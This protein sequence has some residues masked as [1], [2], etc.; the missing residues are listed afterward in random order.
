VPDAGSRAGL[1]GDF[2]R[3]GGYS[4]T[5]SIVLGTT[6]ITSNAPSS[7]LLQSPLEENLRGLRQRLER[8]T[9]QADR[10]PDA[11]QILAVT[12]SVEPDA[13]AEIARLG[14]HDLGENRAPE[15]ERK[16]QAFAD[17]GSDGPNGVPEVRWHFIGHLQRNKAR[18]VARIASVIHSVDSL[19]LLDT[20]ERIAAEEDLQ[21]SI[22]LQVDATG[23]AQ[24]TGFAPDATQAA[25]RRAQSCGRLTLLGIMGMGP[26]EEREGRTTRD[27]FA[28]LAAL[29]AELTSDPSLAD[30]FAGGRCRLSMGMSGDLEEAVSAGTDVVRVGGALF[31]DPTNTANK[32]PGAA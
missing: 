13:A 23:E 10:R 19:E 9:S 4:L 16:A 28:E 32:R 18:R 24:K 22:Y 1:S 2:R 21:L 12:K 5:P 17:F 7:P 29:A 15:L 26:L 14:M 3:G 20:L 27:V 6:P 30:A 31:R 11:V 8:A 25:V